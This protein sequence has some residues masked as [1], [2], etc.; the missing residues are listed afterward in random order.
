MH[1]PTNSTILQLALNLAIQV[2]L[3]V[4][5]FWRRVDIYQYVWPHFNCAC[6]ETAIFELLVKSWTLKRKPAIPVSNK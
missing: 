3:Q 1:Q 2:F 4:R 5:I 6:A